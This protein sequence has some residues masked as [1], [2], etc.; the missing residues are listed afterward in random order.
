MENTR[1]SVRVNLKR[2]PDSNDLGF[3][4]SNRSSLTT[5]NS[6]AI[7]TSHHCRLEFAVRDEGPGI[8]A[9][10]QS[11]LFQEFVQIRPG[12]MQKG[13]GSGVGLNL[14]KRIVELMGGTIHCKSEVGKGSTFSFIIP[15]RIHSRASVVE[16]RNKVEDDGD[17]EVKVGSEVEVR[18]RLLREVVASDPRH[19]L[20]AASRSADRLRDR[21]HSANRRSYVE[22]G[23]VAAH[24]VS[25]YDTC[26]I[27]CEDISRAT[28]TWRILL[29]DGEN[30]IPCGKY[31]K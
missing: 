3:L 19:S 13:G 26:D 14:C 24:D 6:T 7:S 5:R 12:E 28:L 23:A 17:E 25:G 9:E 29:V 15:F 20:V 16:R 1:S 30:K 4:N 8:S 22:N 10:D 21:L 18:S 2:I 11:K 31:F 27:F